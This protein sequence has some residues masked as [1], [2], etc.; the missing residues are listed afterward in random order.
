[1]DIKQAIAVVVDGGDLTTAQMTEVMRVIMAGEATPAQIGGFLIALRL[2][3]ETVDEIAGAATVMRELVT[4]VPVDVPHL[5]DIVGTGGDAAGTFNISTASM[6]V[7]AAAGGHVAKHGNR[8]V[9]SRSG[10]A[11]LLEA[12]GLNLD[13][14]AA[15]VA[16]CVREVGVG[17]MFAPKHHGAMRHAVGPRREMGVRTLFNV[18]GPLTNPAGAPHMLLGVY[19]AAWLRPLAEVL[20]RLGVSHALVVHSED[21]LDEMSISAATQVVELHAGAIQTYRV[22]PEEFGLPRGELA[23]LKVDG[24]AA[25][26]A[27]IRDILDNVP[28]PARDVVQLNAGAAI[29]AADLVPTLAAG[30]ARAGE[31]LAAGAAQAKMM[32]LLDRTRR[33]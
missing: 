1:M 3:G 7:V 15:Q 22:E 5:V 29:Y 21:G 12:A 9:S 33:F 6:F 14:S 27:M 16:T 24:P 20:A 19:S 10:S 26:L 13:L 25:S 23:A 2:K 17:F 28:G 31:L 8:S 32:A 30:V 11:D 4:G 18:L